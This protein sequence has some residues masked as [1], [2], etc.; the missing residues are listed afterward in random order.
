[1]CC[2]ISERYG[3]IKDIG[4]RATSVTNNKLSGIWDK[5]AILGPSGKFWDSWSLCVDLITSQST[6]LLPLTICLQHVVFYA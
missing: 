5:A 6:G 4:M 1:M 3:E 2:I